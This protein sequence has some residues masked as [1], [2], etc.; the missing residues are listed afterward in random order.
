MD[1]SQPD[2]SSLV[3]ASPIFLESGN[4]QI[5]AI[6]VNDYGVASD[7]AK[8][9]YYVD[10]TVPEAPVVTPESG[11]YSRPTLLQV[12]AGENCTVYYTTD[13]S[14]PS[15]DSTEYTGPIPMPVGTSHFRFVSY[16]YAG[17]AKIG[18]DQCILF[19]E[20]S[21]V[22]EHGG[23]QKYA[24]NRSDGGRGDPG[25]KRRDPDWDWA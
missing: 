22:S 8:E 7:E 19:P 4:Y 12:T 25:F 11:E 3:Y 20:P 18:R 15:K 24:F 5:R 9:N 23:C 6:F 16:S 17:A 1:G 14:Q 10:V 2:E 21:C 13:G